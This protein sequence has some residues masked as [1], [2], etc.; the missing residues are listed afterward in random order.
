MRREI[1]RKN[2]SPLETSFQRYCF[3][4]SNSFRTSFILPKYLPLPEYP[5]P[6]ASPKAAYGRVHLHHVANLWDLLS[7]PLLAASPEHST[8]PLTFEF[9]GQ[10]HGFVLYCTPLRGHFP[11]PALLELKGLA[12]RAYVYVDKVSKTVFILRKHF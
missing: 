7:T 8:H 2:I 4:F 5:V 9:L 10:A 1:R 11:D 6:G 3:G 12:D